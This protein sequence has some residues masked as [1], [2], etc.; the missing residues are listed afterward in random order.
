MR[1]VLDSAFFSDSGACDWVCISSDQ[2]R[3][4]KCEAAAMTTHH[5]DR[6]SGAAEPALCNAIAVCGCATLAAD[7]VLF[8]LCGKFPDSGCV[9]HMLGA[10]AIFSGTGSSG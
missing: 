9:Q 2:P 6:L 7:D 5:R 1:P 3:A 10:T 8:I 4:W